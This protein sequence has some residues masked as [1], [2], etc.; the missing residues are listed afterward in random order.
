MS[1]IK[2]HRTRQRWKADI[3][4]KSKSEK[5]KSKGGDVGGEEQSPSAFSSDILTL[6]LK[7]F[8]PDFFSQSYSLSVVWSGADGEDGSGNVFSSLDGVGEI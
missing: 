2:P 8:C 7:V 6:L 4:R 5:E 3:K 1:T